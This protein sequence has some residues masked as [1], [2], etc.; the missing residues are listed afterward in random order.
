MEDGKVD[1][2]D[3]RL[4]VLEKKKGYEDKRG[5]NCQFVTAAFSSFL[6][7][8]NSSRLPV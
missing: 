1:R 6:H 5:K 3:G 2:E 8:W 4:K 7:S